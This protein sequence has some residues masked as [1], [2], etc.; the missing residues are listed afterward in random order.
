MKGLTM[1]ISAQLLPSV[2]R[3]ALDA[4]M[5]DRIETMFLQ[6]M[7]KESGL[8]KAVSTMSGGIGEA[9]FASFL[10]EEYARILAS[11]VDLGLMAGQSA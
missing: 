1:K 6:E 4:A 10:T 3:P 9:Q 2:T 11:R 8:G 7:L 5:T